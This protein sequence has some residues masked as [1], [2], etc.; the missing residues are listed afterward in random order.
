M[1]KTTI[2]NTV[3]INASNAKVWTVLADFG[4]V[5]R[6]SPNISKSYL[7]SEQNEGVGTTRHCDFVSMGAQVE[8]RIIEWE[9]GKLLKI[10]IYERKNIPLISGMEAR[11]TLSEENE[12]TR[13]TG[14][15]EYEMGSSIGNIINNLAMKKVNEKTW[16][17]FLAGIKYHVETGHNV[18]KNTSLDTSS[19][20]N[21]V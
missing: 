17:A 16:I 10:D 9:E 6:S 19:V 7:T 13:L 5:S 8:E 2:E 1:K 14:A 15:M 18:E 11:F 3:L 20:S 21:L 12:Q 4:N